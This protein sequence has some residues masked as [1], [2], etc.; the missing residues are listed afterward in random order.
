MKQNKYFRKILQQEM[1]DLHPPFHILLLLI[2]VD[3]YAFILITPNLT[4]YQIT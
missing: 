3:L 1:A 4:H 2:V